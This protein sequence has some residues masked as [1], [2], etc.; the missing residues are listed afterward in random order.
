MTIAAALAQIL[1]RTAFDDLPAL[2]VDHAAMVVSSTIASA[3]AGYGIASSV[4]I[5]ALA[6]EQGGHAGVF[7]LVR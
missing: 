5:R 4:I 6:T 3:A 1:T 7:H 2:A